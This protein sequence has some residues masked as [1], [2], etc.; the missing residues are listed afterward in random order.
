MFDV[1]AAALDDDDV[2]G[3]DD[4]GGDEAVDVDAAGS[5]FFD[6]FPRFGECDGFGDDARVF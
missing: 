2:D 1:D 6:A 4:D 3:D 5:D